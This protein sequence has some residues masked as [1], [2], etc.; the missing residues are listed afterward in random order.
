[1]TAVASESALLAVLR[2]GVILVIV[3][4]VYYR[5]R[6]GTKE[7]L[8]RRQEGLFMLVALRLAGAVL[9]VGALAYV[10]DPGWMAWSSVALPMSARWTGLVFFLAAFALLA[11]TLRNLGPNL[12][13]TVVTRREHSLVTRGP[14]RWVRHPF[15]DTMALLAIAVSLLAANWFIFAAGAIVFAL[16]AI[17]SGIE[18]AKLLAR[19]GE[20]YRAYRERTGRFVPKV[21]WRTHDGA[22]T[23]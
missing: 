3:T 6:A 23:R 11:W 7:P 14:Y 10:I 2:A 8:D 5:V 16:L 18:E 4:T 9:W 13:D 20:P 21:T 1:M 12:T 19:F 15:Y 22:R 17:R